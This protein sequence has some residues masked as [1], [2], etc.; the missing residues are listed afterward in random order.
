MCIPRFSPES[1]LIA[2]RDIVITTQ[3]PSHIGHIAPSHQHA[4]IA[5]T[6]S[7]LPVTPIS[8]SRLTTSSSSSNITYTFVIGRMGE[9]PRSG[10]SL[11]LMMHIGRKP[12]DALKNGDAC[13][14]LLSLLASK[15]AFSRKQR[16][17]RH[18]SMT[19]MNESFMRIPCHVA[20]VESYALLGPHSP[21]FHMPK[22]DR[23]CRRVLTN[24]ALDIENGSTLHV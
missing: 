24:D 15:G 7:Q 10:L 4:S 13:R 11:P 22:G 14:Q 12:A 9:S 23:A 20:M 5:M 8:P 17:T 21:L 19:W 18:K 6:L 16:T 1:P 3:I 2:K